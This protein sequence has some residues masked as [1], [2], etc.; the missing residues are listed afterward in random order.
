MNR[1]RCQA[2]WFTLSLSI[3]FPTHA[4]E[5][6]FVS[7]FDGPTRSTA[8]SYC[9]SASKL[10]AA[11]QATTAPA[12]TVQVVGWPFDAQ[13]AEQRQADAGPRTEMEIDLGEGVTM[14]MA[15]ISC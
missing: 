2:M 12:E 13:Q 1:I 3:A 4:A 5:Q 6:G 10:N 8:T 9:G 11:S 7:L 15:L 14:R